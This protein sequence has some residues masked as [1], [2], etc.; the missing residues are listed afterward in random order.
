M[1]SC[2]FPLHNQGACLIKSSPYAQGSLHP[3]TIQENSWLSWPKS[4]PIL[5]QIWSFQLCVMTWPYVLL[6]QVD[7]S[8]VPRTI[9]IS[10]QRADCKCTLK[11]MSIDRVFLEGASTSIHTAVRARQTNIPTKTNESTCQHVCHISASTY[12]QRVGPVT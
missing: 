8:V 11:Y 12:S 4:G 5:A 6:L 9:Q 2:R 10:D 3:T 1:R 7:P